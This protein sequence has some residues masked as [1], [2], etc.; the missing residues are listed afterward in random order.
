MYHPKL[1]TFSIILIQIILA[2]SCSNKNDITLKPIGFNQQDTISIKIGD[3]KVTFIDNKALAPVHKAG[4][5]GIAEL[6]H[7]KRLQPI[8]SIL[9]RIQPRTY[10]WR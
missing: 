4:Y 8:R 3:L 10:I 6:Y 5:N 1:L 2:L 7:R 9:C